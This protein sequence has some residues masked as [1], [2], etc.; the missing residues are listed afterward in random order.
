[1][2]EWTKKE[3]DAERQRPPKIVDKSKLKLKFVDRGV[4]EFNSSKYKLSKADRN[5]L[6]YRHNVRLLLTKCTREI[7][8]INSGMFN[9]SEYNRKC[10]PG[11]GKSKA[12]ISSSSDSDSADDAVAK[13]TATT[14]AKPP[15]VKSR[16]VAPL[17]DEDSASEKPEVEAE[18][19]EVKAKEPEVNANKPEVEKEKP[20]TKT[21]KPEVKAGSDDDDTADVKAVAKTDTKPRFVL[22]DSSSDSEDE[23]R[24]ERERAERKERE[25]AERKKDKKHDDH[26][27]S[28]VR[29]VPPHAHDV[30]SLFKLL[31]NVQ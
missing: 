9:W 25:R 7:R 3:R 31:Q 23:R 13:T 8:Q 20:E 24:R 30:V 14:T 26:K 12:M 16:P 22:S 18:K 21:D 6:K 27:K 5:R 15:E 19:S 29:S 2:S 11:G 10:R 1:M 17:S 28:H 4:V